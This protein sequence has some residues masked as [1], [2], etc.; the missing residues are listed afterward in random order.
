MRHFRSCFTRSLF[1]AS[2][3]FVLAHGLQTLAIELTSQGYLQFSE[4]LAP[5]ILF[6]GFVEGLVYFAV[7]WPLAYAPV[8]V[9]SRLPSPSG[10]RALAVFTGVGFTLGLLS[11][12]LCA[13]VP[14]L[15]L[16]SPPTYSF[17]CIQYAYPMTFAG[18]LGGYAF[19]RF[20]RRTA[21]HDEQLVDQFS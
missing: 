8:Y 7:G 15:I 18:V 1:M 19:W 14:F 9:V 12:P 16:R 2:I 3:I 5:T 10:R 6:F 21:Q 11:L 20:A 4:I 17:W 13:G